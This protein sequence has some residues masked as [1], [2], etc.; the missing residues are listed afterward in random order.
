MLYCVCYL[1][2]FDHRW[3]HFNLY[4]LPEVNIPSWNTRWRTLNFLM[5]CYFLIIIIINCVYKRA[6]GTSARHHALNDLVAR[7]FA[8]A[9]VPVT[10]EPTGLLRMDGKRPDGVSLSMAERQVDMLGRHCYMPTGWVIRWQNI[11]W[12]RCSS[13]DGSFPE[14]GQVCWPWR[15]LH[16]WANCGWE[17]G[18][19]ISINTGEARETSYLFQRISVLVQHFDAVLLHGSFRQLTAR[20]NDR[21]HLCIA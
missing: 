1:Y 11:S 4:Q 7:S 15:P 5:W 2:G 13:R 16:L 8:S 18:R 21:T 17:L 20:T 6:L 19:W 3:L 9:G 10:K 12:G 14:G